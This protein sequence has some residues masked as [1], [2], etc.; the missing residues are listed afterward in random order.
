MA[1]A[2]SHLSQIGLTPGKILGSL[3]LDIMKP[4]YNLKL[5]KTVPCTNRG[6][7]K[8][9]HFLSS[10]VFQKINR[11]FMYVMTTLCFFCWWNRLY[12]VSEQMMKKN[13]VFPYGLWYHN[14]LWCQTHMNFF[15]HPYEI[16]AHK[17]ASC[18]SSCSH[19]STFVP[20]TRT[21]GQWH[22][23]NWVDTLDHLS[24]V[25]SAAHIFHLVCSFLL[26]GP[27]VVSDCC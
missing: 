12:L 2:Y 18:C 3:T 16:T 20:R 8:R 27:G 15:L 14:K 26:P 7:V 6:G 4:M 1:G 25:I 19:Y 17:A 9:K 13:H 24:R 11:A 23:C 22:D 10:L 21:L 5:N